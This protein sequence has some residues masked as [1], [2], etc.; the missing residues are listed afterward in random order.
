ML[1]LSPPHL[2]HTPPSERATQGFHNQ[3]GTEEPEADEADEA[4]E[5]ELEEAAVASGASPCCP[6]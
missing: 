4:E 6:R 1:S 2:A 5:V 3:G